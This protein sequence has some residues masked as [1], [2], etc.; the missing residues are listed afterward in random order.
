VDGLCRVLIAQLI[1][2]EIVHDLADLFTLAG[3]RDALIDLDRMAAKS[4]DNLLKSIDVARTGRTFARLLTALGVPLVGT[5]AAKTIAVKYGNLRTLLDADPEVLQAELSESDGIGPK[6]AE[7][8]VSRLGDPDSRAML[9]KL[10]GLGVSAEEPV[11]VSAPAEGPL[12][13][14]SFC[15]TGTL[16]RP[17]SELQALIR[18][19]G[20]E[21]HAS[22]KKGTQFLIAGDN[23]GKAKTAA[24]Q[25]KGAEVIDEAR[26]EAMLEE[27]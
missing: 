20:G 12:L 1:D 7:S 16:S 14:K 9:E 4:V 23:V 27:G 3:H 24:A 25:K 18:D 5:V 26:L 19:H 17:R 6:I 2:S 22:V 10:L 8:V 15:I 13:G 11:E 21:V